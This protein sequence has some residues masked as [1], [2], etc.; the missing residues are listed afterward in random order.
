MNT[1]EDLECDRL[2]S[3]DDFILTRCQDGKYIY[4]WRYYKN[5]ADL[6]VQD[7]IDLTDFKSEIGVVT[8]FKM[9]GRIVAR[10]NG[11]SSNFDI[12]LMI[13]VTQDFLYVNALKHKP[14]S[15]M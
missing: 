1:F 6:D 2:E 3:C 13:S 15:E 10:L 14:L 11:H 5:Q 12:V 7:E 8:D 4:V 9:Q